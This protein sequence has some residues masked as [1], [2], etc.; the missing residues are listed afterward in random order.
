M[1]RER[2]SHELT[3]DLGLPSPDS[4]ILR[5]RER[6]KASPVYHSRRLNFGR[7]LDP[8]C[9][10]APVYLQRSPSVRVSFYDDDSDIAKD[11]SVQRI[12]RRTKLRQ[13][14]FFKAL[15]SSIR[16]KHSTTTSEKIGNV[17]EASSPVQK[18]CSALIT[19]DG[20][21]NRPGSS[22]NQ[23]WFRLFLRACRDFTRIGCKCPCEDHSWD[24]SA[25]PLGALIPHTRQAFASNR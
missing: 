22:E 25:Q 21:N 11:G 17:A 23:A 7:L 20:E 15:R 9:H 10:S 24:R 2:P 5:R 12:A 6:Y 13:C 19:A 8:L 1:R 4:A 18:V 3:A 14:S 16:G